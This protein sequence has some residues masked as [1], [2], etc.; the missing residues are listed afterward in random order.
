MS[1]HKYEIRNIDSCFGLLSAY[2][3]LCLTLFYLKFLKQKATPSLRRCDR[4]RSIHMA[5]CL[6]GTLGRCWGG[7]IR[8]RY[9]TQEAKGYDPKPRWSNTVRPNLTINHL[10]LG[11][12]ISKCLKVQ[13]HDNVFN[14]LW[15]AKMSKSCAPVRWKKYVKDE[16]RYEKMLKPKPFGLRLRM[17]LGQREVLNPVKP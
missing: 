4:T 17:L 5:P 14:V 3:A 15:C 11:S 10:G 16:Q 9:Q 1:H 12:L 6:R 2:G 7:V 8:C 13:Y